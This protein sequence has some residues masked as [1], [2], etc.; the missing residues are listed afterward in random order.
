MRIVCVVASL[1]QMDILREGEREGG[2]IAI[3]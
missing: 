3:S 2:F 1:T